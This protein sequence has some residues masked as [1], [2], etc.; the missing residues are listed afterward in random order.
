MYNDPKQNIDYALEF[1]KIYRS[2]PNKAKREVDCLRKQLL[3]S[4]RPVLEDDLIVGGITHNIVGFNQQFVG[5]GYYFCDDI[6]QEM[7]DQ[8]I[9]ELDGE[10]LKEIKEMTEFWKTENT[11]ARIE[12]RFEETYKGE[13][14]TGNFFYWECRLAGINVDLELLINLG[15]GGLK[16]RVGEYRQINGGSDFYDALEDSVD[17]I[18]DVCRHYAAETLKLSETALPE[19]K[20]ELIEMSGILT[21]IAVA[22]PETFREGLQLF[23]IY[24]FCADLVNYGRTDNY[25]GD[26]Y[27]KDI[28]AGILTEDDAI[29]LLCSVYRNMI[30]TEKI[31]DT[32]IIIGGTGRKNPAAADRLALAF[33]KASRVLKDPIP[34]L[35][36]RYYK[37]MDG[38]L[39][40]ETLINIREGAVYPIIYS[41]ETTVPAI[42]KIYG[43]DNKMAQRWVPY[44]CGEYVIEGYGVG[45]PDTGTYLPNALDIVLHKADYKTFEELFAAY[46][47]LLKPACDMMAYHEQLNYEVAGEQACYLHH[48]LL[49]YDCLEKNLPLLEGGVRY[50]AASNEIFGVITCADSLT[51]IKE[52]V[53]DKKLLTLPELAHIL[54]ENFKGY[55][56]ERKLC[57]KA[58]KYGNDD[59]E[60]DAMAQKVFNHIAELIENAGKKT[61]IFPYKIVSVNN[62]QSAELG[63]KSPATACGRLSGQPWNNGNGP[64]I[65]A[66]V[67][68]LTATLNSMAKIDAERHAGVIH[69][70]RLNKDLLAENHDKIKFVLETFFEN[71]GVQVNLS[72]VGR[73][74]LERALKYPEEYKDLLVR[75]GGFSARF[76]ELSGIIQNE[77]VKRTTYEAL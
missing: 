12:N 61:K 24:A 69:N 39:M 51:A 36:L 75:I 56:K 47:R 46:D 68:G 62:S 58:P 42:E 14:A 13:K 4:L 65:G 17:I 43:I 15:L 8:T 74:D 25:L 63:A 38:K 30:K 73:D 20:K 64:S 59:G 35:T 48:S 71:N 55:E 67:S 77:L 66:D 26:L 7:L 45:T 54:D 33:I 21:K 34:Q 23:W 31:H 41:D 19:R 49:M 53:Y 1:T 72:S 22:K 32:R 29:Y 16:E 44:G 9:H 27:A 11:T 37:S 52:L 60:A 3:S 6:L 5:H 50:L 10:Y 2:Q 76:V 70:I 28:D 18:S 40:D 57:R